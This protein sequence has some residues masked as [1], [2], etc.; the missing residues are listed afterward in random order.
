M[1]YAVIADV[2]GNAPALHLAM[3]DALDRGAQGFLFAG[4]YCIR[5]PWPNEVVALLRGAPQRVAIRGNEERYLHVPDGDDGQFAVSRWARNE[6]KRTHIEWIDA[7]P[8]RADFTCEGVAIHMAHSSEA[9]IGDAE[10]GRFATRMLPLRYPDGPVAHDAF[11]ADVRGALARDAALQ[12]RLLDMPGGVYIFGHTH[13]QW[14]ARFGDH[15]LLNP[16]SCG[17][18]LDCQEF[19]AAYALL[20]VQSGEATVEERRV[21]YDAEALI[22]RARA[23]G[24]YR[25]APVWSEIVFGEWRSGRELAMYFLRYAEAYAKRVGDPARPFSRDTW[26]AAFEAWRREANPRMMVSDADFPR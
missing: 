16:G 12:R 17:Q 20:T 2:H 13:S 9:F 10:I 4:D 3:A 8:E 6:L 5:A 15:L 18:P 21:R 1:K 23:T 14:H 24:L 25:E 11:L 19:G 22:A 7:L 26:N